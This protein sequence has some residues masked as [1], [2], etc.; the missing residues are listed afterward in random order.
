MIVVQ[1]DSMTCPNRE[2]LTKWKPNGYLFIKSDMIV[3]AYRSPLRQYIFNCSIVVQLDKHTMPL[4]WKET[5]WISRITCWARV[6]TIN[7]IER[8]SF[9][10]WIR[11]VHSYQSK[12]CY[13]VS[14]T[15][16]ELHAWSIQSK[17]VS[18]F[19]CPVIYSLFSYQVCVTRLISVCY[20]SLQKELCMSRSWEVLEH[21]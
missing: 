9:V 6:S 15:L 7:M 19:F 11:S 5:K 10:L 2:W 14:C 20:N 16:L 21:F 12:S 18:C 8:P 4:L 13:N 3:C 1:T 17:R